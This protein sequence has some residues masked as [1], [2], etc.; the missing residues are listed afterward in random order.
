MNEYEQGLYEDLLEIQSRAVRA[1]RSELA[2]ECYDF[3][4]ELMDR[5]YRSIDPT[6]AAACDDRV[7]NGIGWRP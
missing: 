1:G 5:Y 3:C 4:M 6:Y 2:R 7:R